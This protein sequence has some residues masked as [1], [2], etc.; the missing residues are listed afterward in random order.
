MQSILHL[1]GDVLHLHLRGDAPQRGATAAAGA[2][3]VLQGGDGLR[4]VNLVGEVE[5]VE[6]SFV[7]RVR[8]IFLLPA[9]PCLGSDGLEVCNE[10]Q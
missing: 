10:E 9:R 4:L 3:L 7:E 6:K 8:D 2:L 5:L 1:R